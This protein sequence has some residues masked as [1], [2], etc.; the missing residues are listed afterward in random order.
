[1]KF[2]SLTHLV[3]I[4]LACVHI[5]TPCVQALSTLDSFT[6]SGVFVTQPLFVP[7]NF[8]WQFTTVVSATPGTLVFPLFRNRTRVLAEGIWDFPQS[9]QGL[10]PICCVYEL[11]RYYLNFELSSYLEHLGPCDEVMLTKPTKTV[12]AEQPT[13]EAASLYTFAP[14]QDYSVVPR[15]WVVQSP[16]LLETETA[17]E[18]LPENLELPWMTTEVPL[19]NPAGA[20]TAVVDRELPLSF[21]F[22]TATDLPLVHVQIVPHVILFHD[23]TK[24]FNA[25]DEPTHQVFTSLCSDMPAPA[26]AL[27]QLGSTLTMETNAATN[28][29]SLQPANASHKCVWFCRAGFYRVPSS[30]EWWYANHPGI[31]TCAPEP[32]YTALI[33]VLLRLQTSKGLSDSALAYIVM[34]LSERLAVFT[35]NRSNASMVYSV[36]KAGPGIASL[37]STAH[38]TVDIWDLTLV[39]FTHIWS[40]NLSV[41]ES[42]V[43]NRLHL[44]SSEW[45]PLEYTHETEDLA[46][47]SMEVVW[48]T[49]TLRVPPRPPLRV[50]RVV[51]ILTIAWAAAVLLFACVILCKCLLHSFASDETDAAA[52]RAHLYSVPR[53]LVSRAQPSPGVLLSN[54]GNL[55]LSAKR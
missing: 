8:T 55:R 39:F 3:H 20:S 15:T 29:S 13:L 48:V 10:V 4:V 32:R 18:I 6:S 31:G 33:T 42:G 16:S 14:S 46:V 36:A 35:V 37:N 17:F 9:C 28:S 2:P 52:Q 34:D 26:N 51:W 54:T 1:M 11:E 45:F 40:R 23:A 7:S 24:L 30:T 43:T 49:G 21:V 53:A 22:L 25:P 44:A 27:W 50:G 41:Q 38:A 47:Y 19:V 5:T 12:L